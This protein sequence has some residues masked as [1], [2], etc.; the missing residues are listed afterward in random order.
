MN[1]FSLNQQSSTVGSIVI[2]SGILA[3]QSLPNEMNKI[4][5]N[6]R[7]EKENYVLGNS[8]STFSEYGFTK[9]L[10]NPEL[11]NDKLEQVITVFYSKLL[12]NQEPL[13]EEFEEVLFNNLWELYED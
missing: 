6:S 4:Y 1:K 9:S 8:S 5:S 11:N 12:A 13:G 7:F 10:F 2:M 3:C